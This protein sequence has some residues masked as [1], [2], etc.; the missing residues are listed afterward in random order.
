MTAPPPSSRKP[1]PLLLVGTVLFGFP[2]P[3]SAVHL[4]LF[5]FSFAIGYLINWILAALLG[6]CAFKTLTLGPWSTPRGLS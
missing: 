1:F 6:L 2:A 4:L 3:A 5:L